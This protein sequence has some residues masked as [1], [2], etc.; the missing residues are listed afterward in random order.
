MN[1][2]TLLQFAVAVAHEAGSIMRDYAGKAR[3]S[4][5]TKS[6]NTPVTEADTKINQLLID[7]V[8]TQFPDHGVLGEEDSV[9][10]DRSQLWVCDPI[11]G[12]AGFILGAPTAMFS[13][14]YVVDGEPQVAVMYEPLLDKMFT[15]V[16]DQGAQLNGQPLQVSTTDS[17]YHASVGVTA[18]VDQIFARKPF[19]D[20]LIEAKAFISTVPG[21]VFKASLVSQG[22]MDAFVFPGRGAHDIAAEKLIIEEAGGK[23]TSLEGQEQ[24]YD[25]AIRGAVVSNGGPIHDALVKLLKDYGVENYL[26]Y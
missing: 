15:A 14:A 10:T 3:E 7:R 6:N 17:L 11:D 24:R 16:K 20:A 23:V 5:Q 8:Q 1:N 2:E 12:T 9:H 13:L 21:N 22:L 18:S 26:G 19:F 25:R 4:V